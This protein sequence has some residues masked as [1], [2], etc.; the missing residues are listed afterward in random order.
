MPQQ[1]PGQFAVLAPMMCHRLSGW[2]QHIGAGAT[3]ELQRGQYTS[4]NALA[5]R[6]M[7]GADARS[8][9]EIDGNARWKEALE[10]AE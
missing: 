9:E 7:P 3:G 6:W 8:W 1:I 10:G 4:A 5:G 2:V